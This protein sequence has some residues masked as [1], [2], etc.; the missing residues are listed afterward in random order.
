MK[1]PPMRCPVCESHLIVTGQARIET[2]AEH[3]CDPNGTP[4]LK[5]KYECSY[6]GCLSQGNIFWN[7]YGELYSTSW[8]ASENIPFINMNDAPFGSFQRKSNVEIYCKGL[9][10]SRKLFQ[11]FKYTVYVKYKYKSNE[12]GDILGKTSKIQVTKKVGSFESYVTMP[13]ARI[14]YK[15]KRD[16]RKLKYS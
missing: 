4:S 3:V 11:I 9:I 10:D 5:D 14:S 1:N 13:W 2:L 7:E 15:I 8:S 6:K 12:N 16:F